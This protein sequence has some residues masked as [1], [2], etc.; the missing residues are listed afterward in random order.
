[1]FQ[2]LDHQE[3]QK[4][5]KAQGLSELWLPKEI[6]YMKNPP[7]LGSGKFDYITAETLYKQKI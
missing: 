6:I 2:D 1:M 5:F 4:Y 3:I 7:L